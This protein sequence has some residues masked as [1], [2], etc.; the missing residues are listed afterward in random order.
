MKT[1]CEAEEYIPKMPGQL[2]LNL[3]NIV[4][5]IVAIFGNALIIVAILKSKQLR[6]QTSIYFILSLALS[7]FLVGLVVQ[8][9]YSLVLID[10]SYHTCKIHHYKFAI[11]FFTCS[12]SIGNGFCVCFD[13]MLRITK[14]FHY[15]NYVTKKRALLLCIN[16]WCMGVA[17][18]VMV[19][20][21]KTELLMAYGA[22][23][24]MLI[25]FIICIYCAVQIYKVG[26]EQIERITKSNGT[27]SKQR[28][29]NQV[30][31]ERK[32]SSSLVSVL[33]TIV[34]CWGPF[35]IVNLIQYYIDDNSERWTLLFKV[36]LWTVLFGYSKSTINIFIFGLT[37]RDITTAIR[38]I[39]AL[40][41][42]KQSNIE[43]RPM[44][45]VNSYGSTKQ[46]KTPEM[47][48]ANGA[49]DLP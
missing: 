16:M 26:Q 36:R 2:V 15:E 13:R 35:A 24:E 44:S 34:I 19:V 6:S 20:Q 25:S 45:S 40:E 39:L 48:N 28:K 49:L 33:A 32:L 31:M 43:L 47:G 10:W 7:D 1:L 38:N 14:P 17:V 21:P 30:L 5:A 37:H 22:A 42:S 41:D 27:D 23:V 11:A 46:Q 29:K 4:L 9:L 12:V 8:P 18:G 3:I